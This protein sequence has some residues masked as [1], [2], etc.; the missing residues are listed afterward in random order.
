MGRGSPSGPLACYRWAMPL[1]TLVRHGQSEA[2][3]DRIFAGHLDSPLTTLGEAQA[4]GAREKLASVRFQRV[5]SSDLSR[6]HRTALLLLDGG[7]P[8]Q[9]FPELRERY[10]GTYEGRPYAEA[11]ARGELES[12]FRAF[13]ARPPGGESLLDVARRALSHLSELDDGRDVLVVCH[14]ALI[15]AVVGVLDGKPE[16]EIGAYHPENLEFVSR[17]LPRGALATHLGRLPAAG[18]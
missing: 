4:R 12:I 15:R 8:V 2:N 17:E 3:R 1:W 13:R 6:A 7:A 14:G 11:E 9:P 5:V 10:C 16:H 18:G